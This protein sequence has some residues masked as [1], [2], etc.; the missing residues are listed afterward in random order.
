MQK[1]LS[2]G[3]KCKTFYLTHTEKNGMIKTVQQLTF[4]LKLKNK[5][6]RHPTMATDD[7]LV[8]SS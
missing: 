8:V 7:F 5:T 4:T 1:T 3:L 6:D 2:Y